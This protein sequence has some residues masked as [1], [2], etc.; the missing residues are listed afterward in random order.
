MTQE[1]QR[2]IEML[3][4]LANEYM[5]DYDRANNIRGECMAR[6]VS[7]LERKHEEDRTLVPARRE[8]AMRN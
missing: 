7:E 5:L 1:L 6:R 8:M 4:R 3:R 2:Q